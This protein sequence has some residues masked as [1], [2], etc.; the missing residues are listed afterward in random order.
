[1]GRNWKRNQK[2]KYNRGGKK[3]KPAD[4][5]KYGEHKDPYKLISG[6]NYKLEAYYAYQDIHQQVFDSQSNDFLECRSDEQKEEERV[7]WLESMKSIL[8][9]SFRIGRDV[10]VVLRDRLKKELES[11]VGKKM[12]IEVTPK[13]GE[14]RNR[15]LDLKS[16]FKM[17]APAK[18]VTFIPHAYQLNLD[19][20]TIRRNPS[21][22]P[23][24]EWLKVQTEAGF[25]TRQETVSMIPPVVL[26]PE[27]HHTVLD[28]CAAPGSKTSQLLEVLNLPANP[29]DKEPTGVVVANDSDNKRAYMLVHQLRRINS[30][31]LFV[32]NCDAQFFPLIRSKEHPSEGA[33]DRVLCDV[34][35]SGDGTSRKN[36]GVWKT[37]N[38]LNAFGL[39]ALQ[40]SIALKGASLTRVGGYVCYSTC[41]MNPIENESV[42]AELLRASE[43]SLE[44]VDKRCDLPG[45]IARPGM[46]TWK[47]LSE[48]K[49]RRELK[50]KMKK[51]NSKMQAR[52]REWEVKNK[53][54]NEVTGDSEQAGV[55]NEDMEDAEKVSDTD[56]ESR[57]PITS[58][59]KPTSYDS[60]E[61]KKM[62]KM[63]GLNE[64]TS[65]D[66][67][68]IALQKRI[69]KSCFP[70]T[71]EETASFNLK[72]CM[73]ILPQ[74]M[75]TGGFFVALLKKVAPMSSRARKAF[76][77]LENDL[78][79]K[80]ELPEREDGP[81][82]KRAK[83]EQVAVANENDAKDCQEVSAT[84]DCN[85][86]PLNSENRS[87]ATPGNVKKHY[88]SDKDGNKHPSLGRDD[89][90]PLSKEIFEPLKEY[91]GLSSD[92]F[93]ANQYM[94]RACG[95]SKV[96]YFIT[97]TIRKLIDDGLQ[98]RLT[99]VTS[100]V[101]GFVRNNKECDVG[102][103]VSQEGVHFVA[104]HMTKRKVGVDLEDFEKCLQTETILLETFSDEFASEV[105]SL[106]MGSF[107][108]YLNGFED[109]YIKKFVVVMWRCRGDAVNCLVNKAELNGM[110]SKVRSVMG[111]A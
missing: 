72:H 90:I 69:R 101:K 8:P 74:D 10:D 20:Q 21:L 82:P 34:P 79:E 43:G 110:K 89:F 12:E 81:K 93:D 88:L 38:A 49:S 106:S 98:T 104:P 57:V 87:S 18:N 48:D 32:T 1:M 65:F 22:N 16:E 64:Y 58:A 94:G 33:F 84:S 52:R 78:E 27:R 50:D 24:H 19:R 36:P 76:Q 73:R 53:K 107:V 3:P 86:P 91:Y 83:V 109:D 63:A 62:A 30:P 77:Q 67:V 4:P 111:K 95:D 85:Q 44:L 100:G 11:Y 42:V 35:C 17:I 31:A 71:D 66:E 47:V 14:R 59:Y 25:I 5:S 70:P 99:V 2:N 9:A 96:L 102:F 6:G 40:L 55:D 28:M 61:L 23:F 41:S 39:H 15:E 68:P 26:N 75:N 108:V 45:L 105:R 54:E 29:N 103:R 13:G 97:K 7:K 51:K 56:G 37:W 60:V 80:T 46:S 92:S